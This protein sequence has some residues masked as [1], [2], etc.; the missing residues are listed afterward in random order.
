[1][2]PA[3]RPKAVYTVSVQQNATN[4]EGANE[5]VAFLLG[6]DGQNLL[7]EHGLTLQEMRIAGD[8]SAIPQNIKA[9]IDKAK[10][11]LN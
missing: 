11:R 4:P 6:S 8:A 3:V 7:K 10:R 9:I 1:L 5:F 2:P